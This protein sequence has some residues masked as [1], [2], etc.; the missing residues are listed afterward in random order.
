MTIIKNFTTLNNVSNPTDMNQNDAGVISQYKDI[1]RDQDYKLQ[2]LQSA[3]KKSTDEL[4]NMKKQL[5]E[6]QQ[7]NTQLFDQN[8]LLKAQLAATSNATTNH[9]PHSDSQ[10]QPVSTST[11]LSFY[12]ME[13]NRLAEEVQNLN[14]K[15]NDALDMTEQSLNLTEVGRLRKDQEDLLELL[16]DQVCE[17]LDGM[18]KRLK[19]QKC[20]YFFILSGSEN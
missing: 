5:S 4:E 9:Q 8:I 18:M 6:M 16:T 2:N 11:E 10:K 14:A 20:H 19:Y 7:T 1:I 17:R 13:N 15:L 3:L 12:Q